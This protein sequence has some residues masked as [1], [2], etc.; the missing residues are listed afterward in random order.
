LLQSLKSSDV[1]DRTEILVL[2]DHGMGRPT[3]YAG[4]VSR[5]ERQW[6]SRVGSANPVFLLK[7]R[8]DRGPLKNERAAVYLPDVGATLCRSSGACTVPLGVPVGE[9]PPNRPRRYLEYEWRHEFWALEEIPHVQ[10]F[11]VRGLPWKQSS[12]RMIGESD[13]GEVAIGR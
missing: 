4:R 8:G 12:W 7:P 5:R 9:A 10:V 13:P 6:A 3:R 11:E 1:Y 2:A